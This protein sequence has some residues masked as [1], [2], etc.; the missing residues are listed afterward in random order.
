MTREEAVTII[1]KEKLQKYN[2]F[3]NK[4][5]REDE[6]VIKKDG[7]QWITFATGERASELTL[8]RE[9]FAT[10]SEALEDFI[11]RLRCYNSI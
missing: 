4:S 2:F 9:T 8:S 5:Y 7:N 11:R 10:E 1:K 3:E 6:I